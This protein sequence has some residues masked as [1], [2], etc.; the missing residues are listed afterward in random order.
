MLGELDLFFLSSIKSTI[1][2]NFCQWL[3]IS[4]LFAFVYNPWMDAWR[5]KNRLLCF[6][7]E[8]TRYF[9]WCTLSV[10]FRSRSTS[11][12]GPLWILLMSKV[13]V[14]MTIMRYIFFLTFYWSWLAILPLRRLFLFSCI[15]VFNALLVR[16]NKLLIF[17]FK[18]KRKLLLIYLQLNFYFCQWFW[19][20]FKPYTLRM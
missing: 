10:A 2:L 16:F 14:Y 20:Q 3:L 12:L 17:L 13:L 15:I 5:F 9:V 11:G 4:Q 7:L 6:N 8:V 18:E 19:V 1:I